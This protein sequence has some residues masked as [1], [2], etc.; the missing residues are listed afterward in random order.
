MKPDLIIGSDYPFHL[1]RIDSLKASI[2]DR[3]S[4]KGTFLFML[5][6]W[7]WRGLFILIYFI[8]SAF[9]RIIGLSTL[10]VSFK[11]FTFYSQSIFINVL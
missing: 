6:L 10:E 9:I 7:I 8:Y 1:A 3:F 4:H 5:Y 11:L 2:L